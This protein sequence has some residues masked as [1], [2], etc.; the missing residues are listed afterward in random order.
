MAALLLLAPREFVGHLA[1]G[2]EKLNYRIAFG[3]DPQHQ[4]ITALAVLYA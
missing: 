1:I 3:I 2:V 4:P